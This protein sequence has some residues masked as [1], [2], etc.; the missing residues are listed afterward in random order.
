MQSLG[1]SHVSHGME[2][3]MKKFYVCNYFGLT[4]RIA[5]LVRWLQVQVA[6]PVPFSSSSSTALKLQPDV[7]QFPISSNKGKQQCSKKSLPNLYISIM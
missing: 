4:T 6:M 2:I 1:I 5:K 7:D 3:S